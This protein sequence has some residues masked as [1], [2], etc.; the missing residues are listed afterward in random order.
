MQEI[1]HN[2]FVGEL[3][4]FMVAIPEEMAFVHAT[5]TIHYTKMGWDRTHNKPD[6]EHPNYIV[7]EEPNSISLNWVDG[8]AF[9][10]K[11][12]GPETFIKVLDFIDKR[13]KDKK[14]LVHCDQ[15]MSRGPTIGL[16]YLAKRAKTISD[17]S[18]DDAYS[19][20]IKIYPDYNPGGIAEYVRDN[21][22]QIK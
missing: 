17:E 13:I 1:T 2:L 18:F 9:L 21:W 22:D 8:G 3:V 6:K 11:M 7:F 14:V 4:D 15:G 5:Q 20:F 10:Y 16:L 12:S 19:E